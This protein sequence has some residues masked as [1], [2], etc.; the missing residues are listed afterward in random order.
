MWPLFQVFTNLR[1]ER[2]Q[3]LWPVERSSHAACCLGFGSEQPHLL[4]IGGH[5]G[6]WNGLKDCWLFDVFRR[7][8]KE[9]RELTVLVLYQFAAVWL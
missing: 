4:V 7:R 8:W 9:V 2:E 1:P 5:C 6:D 3:Q